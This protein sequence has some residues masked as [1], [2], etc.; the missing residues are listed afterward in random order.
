MPTGTKV[1]ALTQATA[2]D[3]T[4]TDKFLVIDG[5]TSKYCTLTNL[6]TAIR[7]TGNSARWKQ[8]PA[9]SY[10]ATPL[11]GSGSSTS[12]AARI[13]CSD[14]SLFAV[15]YPVNYF[16][17][18]NAY[19]GV[20]DSLSANTYIEVRGAPMNTASDL[21]DLYVGTATDVVV[22]NCFIAGDYGDGT[23]DLL[24]NDMNAYETWDMA[25]AY[26]VSFQ[27]TNGYGGA[28]GPTQPKI[29]VKVGG[30]AVSDMDS[31]NGIQM[32]ATAGTWTKNNI[33][34]IATA[35]YKIEL[36][37]ALEITCTA[38]A[39]GGTANPTDLNIKLMFVL[40]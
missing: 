37:D 33:T 40:E 26:L 18:G 25:D 6:Q 36:D 4:A 27:A 12:K 15:G 34:D 29:N 9:A 10:T 17:G 24:A 35:N 32:N 38:A 2:T 22:V 28:G 20:V 19:F 14:T 7:V 8:V 5:S 23:N 30:N 16:Y 21:T 3:L 1:S 39:A 13:T 11:Q 31:S